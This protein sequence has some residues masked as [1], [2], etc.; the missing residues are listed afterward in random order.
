MAERRLIRWGIPTNSPRTATSKCSIQT[1]SPSLSTEPHPA[2]FHP[3]CQSFYP[4][5]RLIN[6][7][8]TNCH[9]SHAGSFREYPREECFGWSVFPDGLNRALLMLARYCG[10]LSLEDRSHDS[11]LVASR[12]GQ[13]WTLSS[14]PKIRRH[15][16]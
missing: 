16:F 12:G 10:Q 5:I 14:Q 6:L 9:P 13:E 4:A 8:F 7:S 2:T 1:T 11:R 15:D 3:K